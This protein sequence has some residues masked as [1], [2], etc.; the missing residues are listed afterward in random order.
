MRFLLL[1]AMLAAVPAVAA[2]SPDARLGAEVESLCFSSQINRWSA[3]E[4]RDGAILLDRGANDWYLADITEG[5]SEKRIRRANSIVTEGKA[6]SACL[7][8]NDSISVIDN[9]GFP[10]NCRIKRIYKWNAKGAPPDVG[11]APES[12]GGV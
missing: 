10:Y 1:P 9:S 6:G 7:T 8:V 3:V 2:A 11:A 4:G 12:S 5:C